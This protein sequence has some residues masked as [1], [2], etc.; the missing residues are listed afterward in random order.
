MLDPIKFGIVCPGMKPDGQ[1]D[2][3]GIPADI[4]TAYLG[5]Q[6]IVPSRTTDHMVLFLFSVGITK[7]K[8]GTLLNA[9]LDFKADYDRNAPLAEVLPRVLAAAPER[10]AGMGLKD[11]GDELWAHMKK[12]RQGHWQAQAYAT[13]PTPE[14]TPRRAFQQLMGG[15]AE[16]VPLDQMANRVV[17]VG[18]IPYPPGIPI[19]MPGENV[20]EADGPWLTYLRTLQ[21]YGH[22]FPGFG[23]EVE[24]TEERDGVYHIYCLK[25]VARPTT[26]ARRHDA[27]VQFE[28]PY[29]PDLLPP[30]VPGG[31]ARGTRGAPVAAGSSI[32][33]RK[34]SSSLK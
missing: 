10:Y 12:S 11:L 28:E 21:E 1:L 16:K 3:K 30:A 6:G 7:G 4:V 23:K 29:D 34:R 14:M 13:L 18:V 31:G 2:T 32:T 5:R 15:A 33:S 25:T 9:L 19:V 22:R 27:R 24:G 8:W 26:A 20:G 17:A